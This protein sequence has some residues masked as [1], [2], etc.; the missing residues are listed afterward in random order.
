M[1]QIAFE[2]VSTQIFYQENKDIT[3][4]NRRRFSFVTLVLLLTLVRVSIPA[5]SILQ[6]TQPASL[7][8]VNGKI[9]TA[10]DKL[11]WATAIAL[12]GNK[13]LAVGDE[14][15]ARRFINK[16]TR[17]I[18]LKGRF[19]M[20]GIN[21]SHIH[22]LGGSLGLFEVNL[23]GARSLEEM[24]Q[25]VAK[26]AKE[27]PNQ[28]WITG[29]GWEYA[30]FPIK[31]LPTKADLDL[32]VSDR[33]VFLRAYDGHTAWANSKALEIARVTAASKFSGYGEM[34][35][36]EKTKEPTGVLKEGAM[37]LVSR[38]IPA[39]TRERK[40]EALRRGLQEAA[41]LGIT[42]IQNAS[43]SL[44]EVE[45]YEELLKRGELSLRVTFAIS[46][47][48]K[49]TQEEI[50]RIRGLANKYRGAHLRI[51]AIKIVVDGV[52]ET[53]TAAMLA[54]YSN[55]TDTSGSSA[56]T[57]E[58]LD[59]LVAMADK[60]G[61]QV[62]I[63]AIGDKGVRMA[64]DAFENAVRKNGKHDS[65]FRIEHIETVAPA[66]IPRFKQI[67]VLASMMPLHADPDTIAVW[68]AAI[69]DDRTSRGFAWRTLE[70]AGAILIFSS[71]YPANI[72]INPF[73]GIH[74]A[75]NRQTI[76]GTPSSGWHPE[77]R[78]SLATTLKAYTANGAFAS[79]EERI[80][81]E[82]KAGM[83]ADFV[84]LDANLFAVKPLDLY[85]TQ[86]VTTVF[87]G[88]V[89][90]GQTGED[91]SSGRDTHHLSR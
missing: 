59:N 83:L 56:Y 79:F 30:Y 10:D 45:L 68:S 15:T 43:G 25:R 89:I 44:A 77:L 85:K 51:G 8:F 19:V 88:R 20:P 23:T 42:S 70:M 48:P 76:E 69:G 35:V 80:K 26:F 17:V 5:R 3:M 41:S 58:Q 9:W 63:H 62:Y 52:I 47:N 12:S 87:D 90:H 86:V 46:V 29:S 55:K 22:F 6:T 73:R 28:E 13:V 1:C 24:Q 4:Q 66:D 32:I 64:L 39:P 75:V 82:L 72:S 7:V 27:N 81:G 14:K 65:R 60:A 2:A 37:S 21:D 33:P 74:N 50:T 53:Y 40:L 38:S 49:T 31:R 57:Q 18:D 91:S 34:V 71:D 54:P 11:R 84:V 67:G 16:D 61:L 36:D 78:V